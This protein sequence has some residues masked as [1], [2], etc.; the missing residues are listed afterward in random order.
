[1]TTI[2]SV[3]YRPLVD[4]CTALEALDALGL[5]PEP[6]ADDN[7]CMPRYGYV[8]RQPTPA[9][10]AAVAP[11]SRPPA[12]THDLSS[13]PPESV[14]THWAAGIQQAMRSVSHA[15]PALA[16]IAVAPVPTVARKRRVRRPATANARMLDVIHQGNPDARGWSLRQWAKAL[17]M[18]TGAICDTKTWRDLAKFRL[19][20]RAARAKDRH[21]RMLL[22]R[23]I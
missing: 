9:T 12:P 4:G 5:V 3:I 19:D 17:K 20:A 18:S 16:S 22:A 15:K 13:P 10:A 14:L 11:A 2:D 21:G 23:E 6:L 1:M 7:Y 8:V